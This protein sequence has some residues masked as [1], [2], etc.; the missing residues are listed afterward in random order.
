MRMPERCPACAGRLQVTSLAC[1]Q[2]ATRIEGAFHVCPVCSLEGDDRAL[3]E[4]FLRVRGNA[5]E[6]E[7]MLGVSYPTVRARLDRLWS[8]LNLP[9]P[10]PETAERPALEILAKVREGSI[11]VAQ[12]IALLRSRGRQPAGSA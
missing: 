5:K 8:R 4:L 7:R 2:C 11:G 6:V 12:A 3:L 1:T 10:D 9:P